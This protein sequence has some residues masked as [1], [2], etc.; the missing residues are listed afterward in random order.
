MYKVKLRF[1]DKN[2]PEVTFEALD[3][4]SV[5]DVALDNGIELH[6]N[7]GAVNACSTC[8]VYIQRGMDTLPEITEKEEDFI[9]RAINPAINSRLGCQCKINGDLE[10]TIPDQRQFHGH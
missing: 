7:C 8:H 6:H 4:D 1:E 2:I 9:D 3:G 10:V 5:L